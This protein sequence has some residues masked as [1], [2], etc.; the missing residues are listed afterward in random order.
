MELNK[1]I[2]IMERGEGVVCQRFAHEPPLSFARVV[3]IVPG[4]DRR[5]EPDYTVVCEDRVGC[6]CTV[7][8]GWLSPISGGVVSA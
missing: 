6:Q 3:A 2:D 4:Y 1:L 5:G 7:S 8:P